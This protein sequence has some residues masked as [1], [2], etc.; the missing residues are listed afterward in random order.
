VPA[1]PPSGTAAD[2][3][4]VQVR[5]TAGALGVTVFLAGTASL[6]TEMAA[7]RRIAPYFGSSN[8][9]WANVIGLMLT[10]LAVG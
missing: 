4:N 9:V 10:F 7:A 2:G 3:E 1:L 5:V 6:A 8:V